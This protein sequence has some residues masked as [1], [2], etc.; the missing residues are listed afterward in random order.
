MG[1]LYG[2]VQGLARAE[3]ARATLLQGATGTLDKLAAEGDAGS[4]A[5]GGDGEAV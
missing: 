5:G 2:S 3:G 1:E 4:G